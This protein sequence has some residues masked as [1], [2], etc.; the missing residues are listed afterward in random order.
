MSVPQIVVVVT[1]MTASPTPARGLRDRLDADVARAVEDGRAHRVDVERRRAAG[2]GKRHGR[3]PY[4][5]VGGGTGRAS[6][7]LPAAY[8]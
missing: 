4:R 3:P 8:R 5:S 7:G 1:R 2:F 6:R